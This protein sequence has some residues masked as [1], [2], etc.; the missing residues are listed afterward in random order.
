MVRWCAVV[1]NT[2]GYGETMNTGSVP[3]AAKGV[4]SNILKYEGI[5][6]WGGPDYGRGL[7][8]STHRL[9]HT[10]RMEI[11]GIKKNGR[12]YDYI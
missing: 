1:L 4:W 12:K 3:Y 7:G 11:I 9:V 10:N 6:I 5:N 8:M 2:K